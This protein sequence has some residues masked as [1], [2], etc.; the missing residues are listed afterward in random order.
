MKIK[1]SIV[2]ILK[3]NFDSNTIVVG[4]KLQGHEFHEGIN[5]LRGLTCPW[6]T[7]AIWSIEHL[8]KTGFLMISDGLSDVPFSGGVEVKL[9]GTNISLIIL[10]NNCCF[11]K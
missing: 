11:R 6:N 1:P 10:T 9:I 8:L 4:P 3:D 2:S 7:F 5:D